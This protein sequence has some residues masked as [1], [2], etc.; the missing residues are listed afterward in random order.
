MDG[1]YISRED[2]RELIQRC[3]MA[4]TVFIEVLRVMQ[5]NA[6]EINRLRRIIADYERSRRGYIIVGVGDAV[7]EV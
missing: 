6:A 2:A 1:L 7:M 3:Q 5:Q 4:E